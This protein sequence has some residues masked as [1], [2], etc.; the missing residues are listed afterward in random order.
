MELTHTSNETL[1]G[2]ITSVFLSG[3][4]STEYL[5]SKSAS[6]ICTIGCSLT[7]NKLLAINGP[8]C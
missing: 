6:R 8:N 1:M 3:N 5:Y 4:G 2:L 7:N